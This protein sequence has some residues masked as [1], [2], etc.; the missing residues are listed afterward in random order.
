MAGSRRDHRETLTANCRIR[1][2][3]LVLH[4]HTRAPPSRAHGGGTDTANPGVDPPGFRR[5]VAVFVG[6]SSCFRRLNEIGDRRRCPPW[7]L[8]TGAHQRRRTSGMTPTTAVR[9]VESHQ[10][11]PLVAHGGANW[12]MPQ[13]PNSCKLRAAAPCS[14]PFEN[15]GIDYSNRE[16]AQSVR[17][18]GRLRHVECMLPI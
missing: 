1:S 12:V 18:I 2:G 15:S 14:V 17:A 3:C 16:P 7:Q 6:R 11:P 4:L 10:Q 13:R 8:A 9:R 5:G